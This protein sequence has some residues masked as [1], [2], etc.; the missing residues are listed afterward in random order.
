MKKYSRVSYDI[1]CQIYALLQV[2]KSIAEIAR[3]TGFNKSTIYRELKRNK[4]FLN[5]YEPSSAQELSQRRYK[6]CRR[7]YAITKEF[8]PLIKAWIVKGL[9]PEHIAG[10]FKREFKRGPT[11]PTIYRYVYAMLD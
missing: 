1:R 3:V 6:N 11:H 9:S 4:N 2:K 5:V 10:R 8:K 7:Q